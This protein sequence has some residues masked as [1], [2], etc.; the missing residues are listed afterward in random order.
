M[1]RLIGRG[2]RT[3]C[4]VLLQCLVVPVVR[5][6]L[7]QEDLRA[8]LRSG[9]G[10]RLAL[11]VEFRAEVLHAAG[12]CRCPLSDARR[13]SYSCWRSRSVILLVDLDEARQLVVVLVLGVPNSLLVLLVLLVLQGILTRL[14]V[15][16]CDR[17][18]LT[19][20]GMLRGLERVDVVV[21]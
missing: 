15:V 10:L 1:Q 16:V 7:A 19:L 14:V 8:A 20:N 11:S 5:L 3:H 18:A 17:V 2:L 4:L 12:S 6:V 21:V 13:V 9:K